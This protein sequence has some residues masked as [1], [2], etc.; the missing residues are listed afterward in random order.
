[1]WDKPS[2]L[3]KI[4][5]EL[6][7]WL[8]N[9]FEADRE[10]VAARYALAFPLEYYRYSRLRFLQGLAR[11]EQ[12]KHPL[13]PRELL[14]SPDD[15]HVICDTLPSWLLHR[16][17]E[18]GMRLMVADLFRAQADAEPLT[19]SIKRALQEVERISADALVAEMLEGWWEMAAI[20]DAQNRREAP[21]TQLTTSTN[22]TVEACRA[23]MRG[24][25]AAADR[26]QR[27]N[28]RQCI[29]RDAHEAVPLG[30]PSARVTETVRRF[31][32]R[33]ARTRMLELKALLT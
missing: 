20:V 1:M 25:S 14:S 11:N 29:G 28:L 30:F 17:N 13:F 26:R 3:V 23:L 15:V 22:G 2:Q 18:H 21:S 27:S 31:R 4:L 10:S 12:V 19:I 24:I 8:P 32:R 7:R 16:S 6:Y 5:G 9:S 33:E